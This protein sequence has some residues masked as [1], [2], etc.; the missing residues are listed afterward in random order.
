MRREFEQKCVFWG[1][2]SLDIYSSAPRHDDVSE[3][4]RHF[5][6]IQTRKHF[7][8]VSV[9]ILVIN[10]KLVVK[11]SH[12]LDHK[13]LI[14]LD[15]CYPVLFARFHDIHSYQ[16]LMLSFV[17]CQHVESGAN[18]MNNGERANPLVNNWV[19]LELFRKIIYTCLLKVDEV[20]QVHFL[21][22][23]FGR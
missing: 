16:P 13:V 7:D 4:L 21:C 5:N 14:A 6:T 10:H 17:I 23:L 3:Q 12:R 19:E 9:Q 18:I 8:M 15:Q 20:F 2:S 1:V 22:R 11:K